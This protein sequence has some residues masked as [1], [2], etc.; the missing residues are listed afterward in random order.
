L[1]KLGGFKTIRNKMAIINLRD[2]NKFEN[3]ELIDTKKLLEAGL[4]K[5]DHSGVKILAEGKL[6]KK[7]HI[8]AQSFSKKAKEIIE[9]LGGEALIESVEQ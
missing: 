5:N 2:L 7:L 1:P 6:T 8:K 3:D 9:K 4:V